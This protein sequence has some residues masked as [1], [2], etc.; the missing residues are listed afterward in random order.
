[1]KPL[2]KLRLCYHRVKLTRNIIIVKGPWIDRIIWFHIIGKEVGELNSTKIRTIERN[3]LS[4][5]RHDTRNV[6]N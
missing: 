4:A 5:I 1:M 3:I 2:K 6:K